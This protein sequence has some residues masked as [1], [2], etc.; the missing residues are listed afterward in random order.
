MFLLRRRNDVVGVVYRKPGVNMAGFSLKMA[1]VV[2]KLRG[3]N[4]YIL[5][6]FN[7]DLIKVETH[8]PTSKFLRGFTSRAFYP[9]V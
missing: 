4:R 3:V 5:G 7:V 1:Q 6:Y 8:A 2:V 9:L